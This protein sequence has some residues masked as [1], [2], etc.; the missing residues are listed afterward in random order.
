MKQKISVALV[1]AILMAMLTACNSAM[2]VTSTSGSAGSASGSQSVPI[3]SGPVATDADPLTGLT[4]AEGMVEGQRP[5]AVMV[6][7]N[8][9][10]LP[11]RGL[12]SASVIY[13]AVTEGGI[14]RL[15]A[16]YSDYRS[17]PQVGPVRSARDVFIQMAVPTD[18][19]LSH[20][21][22]SVYGSNLLNV[23]QYQD[24]DGYY[25][26]TIAFAFDYGRGTQKAN[27]NCWFTDA[28]LLWSGM[29]RVDVHPTGA[30]QQPLFGFGEVDG[31]QSGYQALLTYSAV[32]TSTFDYDSTSATYLKS[33]NGAPHADEDGTRL[34]FTNVI[35][36]MVDTSL[37]QDAISVE[38]NMEKGTGLYFCKGGVQI[39]NWKKGGPDQELQLFAADG[40]SLTVQPG[41]SYVGL[42]PSQQSVS[43]SSKTQLD[44]VAAAAASA[45]AQP[46]A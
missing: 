31:G 3:V 1:V 42:V 12:A 27:E 38:F 45:A 19:I 6:G 2:S 29:E 25:L 36:L 35:V 11:Q 34:A 21:G 24:V 17:L 14:T 16:V 40:S 15:M 23:L 28:S 20:I 7:N 9:E 46:T 32:S 44:E 43:Y 5:V 18:A 33:Y 37:K 10:A 4:R 22:S 30:V 26:G 8:P 41:K 39:I 13:E